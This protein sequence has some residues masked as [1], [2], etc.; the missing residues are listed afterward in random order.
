MELLTSS[1]RRSRAEYQALQ[2]AS[3]AECR[4]AQEAG[5][6]RFRDA[7]QRNQKLAELGRLYEEAKM[8]EHAVL[9]EAS[10]P[11][12]RLAAHRTT[13]G[14]LYFRAAGTDAQRGATLC[15]HCSGR[16]DDRA[17]LAHVADILKDC[18]VEED[19]L[20]AIKI[21]LDAAGTASEQAR[22]RYLR[23]EQSGEL[24]PVMPPKEQRKK[25]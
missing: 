6:Q 17:T 23:F 1:E 10:G 16:C 11:T 3:Y 22:A 24:E 12:V 7:T 13:I 21:R 19:R 18:K 15:P 25:S 2:D 9:S 5:E 14:S 8:A 4:R 20:A